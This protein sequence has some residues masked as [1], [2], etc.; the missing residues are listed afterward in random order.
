MRQIELKLCGTRKIVAKIN[1]EPSHCKTAYVSIFWE[2]QNNVAFKHATLLTIF[3]LQRNGYSLNSKH[4][5]AIIPL[6][7]TAFSFA[8]P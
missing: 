7:L 8:N 1:M 2:E 3:I 4:C 6:P 5:R